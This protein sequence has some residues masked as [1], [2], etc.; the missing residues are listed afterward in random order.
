MLGPIR[1]NITPRHVR[2]GNF[3]LPGER[4]TVG[5]HQYQHG[6]MYV[7]WEA[8]ADVTR[9]WPIVLVHGGAVQGTEWLD[10]PDGRP[11]WAQRLGDH[12]AGVRGRSTGYDR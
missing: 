7:S 6:A 2:Q 12:A 3:W 9:P 1:E 4:A 8:P 5:D 11:E 10:T